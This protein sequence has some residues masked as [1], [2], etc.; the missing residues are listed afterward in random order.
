MEKSEL[1]TL[2]EEVGFKGQKIIF[3][4]DNVSDIAIKTIFQELNIN[5][6]Q[7]IKRVDFVKFLFNEVVN[8]KQLNI[9]NTI[10]KEIQSIHEKVVL[11]L[12]E[13]KNR[14]CICDKENLLKNIDQ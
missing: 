3:Y 4:L 6:S 1:N 2:V 13:I 10:E 5:K 8:S 9:F 12:N 14:K 7:S 11:K